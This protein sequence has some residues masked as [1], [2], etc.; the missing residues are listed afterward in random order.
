VRED[1]ICRLLQ[2]HVVIDKDPVTAVQKILNLPGFQ[3]YLATLKTKDEKEQFQRHLARYVRIYMPDCPFEVC[4]THRYT[5]ATLEACVITRK[6]I[7]KGETVKYLTGIQV[8]MNKKE[9]QDLGLHNRDFS[10]VMSSRKK[11]PSLFLGPAR[12]ANHDCNANARLATV[13]PHGMQIVTT[14]N[15]DIDEEI[16]VQ[17]G[18]NYFGLNNCECLCATCES[19]WRNGWKV[20]TRRRRTALDDSAVTSSLLDLSA[21]PDEAFSL[22]TPPPETSN[23]HDLGPRRSL[24]RKR[25]FSIDANTHSIVYAAEIPREPPRKRL[26]LEERPVPRKTATTDN[27]KSKARNENTMQVVS[28]ERAKSELPPST[29]S[30]RSFLASGLARLREHYNAAISRRSATRASITPSNSQISLTTI[31][32]TPIDDEQDRASDSSKKAKQSRSRGLAPTRRSL[33]I[34]SPTDGHFGVLTPVDSVVDDDDA[35][36]RDSGEDDD[37]DTPTI[38]R[39]PGDHRA[40]KVQLTTIYSRWIEC[41]NCDGVFI[42]HDAYLTKAYCGRCERHSKLYGYVWPKTQSAGKDDTEE[43]ILDHRVVHKYI[44]NVAEAKER[45]GRT[46]GVILQL[47]DAFIHV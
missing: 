3:K 39:Q 11:I 1:D 34:N 17:Y 43:R 26:K 29:S 19:L 15:I 8:A 9:E 6:P 2:K 41:Q 13:G 20:K 33:R 27:T 30:R 7:A 25:D 24:R 23:G 18:D 45:K 31:E 28:G 21:V 36:N 22:P 4:T 32:V 38:P 40:P 42:Q 44:S 35:D 16:T 10:V 12:F 46:K 14:R 37:E 47:S 5:L